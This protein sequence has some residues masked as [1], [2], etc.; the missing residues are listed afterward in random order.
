MNVAL[1]KWALTRFLPGVLLFGA[2]AGSAGLIHHAGYQSGV[3]VQKLA[4]DNALVAEQKSRADERQQLAEAG[5]KALAEVRERE[6]A[7]R[8]RAD[9]L[10]AQLAGRETELQQTKAL[11]QQSIEGAVSDD[12]K[13]TDCGFTGLGPRGLQLY[14]QALGYAGGG[15]AR[16]GG[17]AGR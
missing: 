11:L 1:I 9:S 10:A 6:Q 8:A 12:N 4:G 5:R 7:Q 2:I 13:T 16:A 17:R 14:E 3:D 15:N